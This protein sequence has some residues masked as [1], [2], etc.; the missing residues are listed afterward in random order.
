MLSILYIW[1]I[2]D[3]G[4]ESNFN[5]IFKTE[6]F[7]H[8]QFRRIGLVGHGKQMGD[9][10]RPILAHEWMV[11][12]CGTRQTLPVT[13]PDDDEYLE[14]KLVICDDENR[15]ILWE[16]EGAEHNRKIRKDGLK[17]SIIHC[18]WG[19]KDAY[20]IEHWNEPGMKDL[21]FYF[22]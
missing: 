20:D 3:L 16:T 18:H 13:L 14:F 1:F 22:I 7:L 5:V 10:C 6:Y 8:D 4:S 17:N 11:S 9:W 19:Y 12:G 15:I 2:L 21:T